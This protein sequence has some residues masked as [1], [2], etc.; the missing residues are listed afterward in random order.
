MRHRAASP[1]SRSDPPGARRW[2]SRRR[3]VRPARSRCRAGPAGPRPPGSG[4]RSRGR[5]GSPRRRGRPGLRRRRPGCRRPGAASRRRPA[6]R[7]EGVHRARAGSASAMRAR[8]PREQQPIQGKP[9]FLGIVDASPRYV[10]RILACTRRKPAA[11]AGSAMAGSP[12]RRHRRGCSQ[13]ATGRSDPRVAS[14]IPFP[15]EPEFVETGARAIE[16]RLRVQVAVETQAVAVRRM[17]RPASSQVRARSGRAPRVLP[18]R[19]CAATT[20]ARARVRP[21]ASERARPAGRPRAGEPPP[22]RPRTHRAARRAP[23]P[24]EPRLRRVPRSLRL[25][26]S[27]SRATSSASCARR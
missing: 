10:V 15:G 18:G 1:S 27:S 14:E 2:L 6:E 19:G 8:R 5:R 7:G 25:G 26:V 12:L 11:L 24:A 23:R 9:P 17:C 3:C 21:R 4:R 13:P 16:A 20:S 22:R